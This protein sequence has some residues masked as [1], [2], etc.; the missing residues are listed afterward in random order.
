QR[1]QPSR[2]PVPH[3]HRR[4]DHRNPTRR[5]SPLHPRPLHPTRPAHPLPEPMNGPPYPL[6]RV[7][8]AIHGLAVRDRAHHWSLTPHRLLNQEVSHVTAP[9]APNP[10]PP[11]PPA[12]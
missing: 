8:T 11:D 10:A 7:E 12:P 3:H 4:P 6:F 5:A 2:A 1:C 9:P